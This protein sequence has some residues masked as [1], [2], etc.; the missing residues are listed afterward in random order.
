MATAGE[1]FRDLMH[2]LGFL[3]RVPLPGRYFVGY[4]GSLDRASG[5]FAVAGALIALPG[6]LLFGLCLHFDVSPNLA[7]LLALALQTGLTGGLHEDGLADCADGFGGGRTRD[8]ILDIMKDSRL[9]AY[10]GMALVFSFLLRMEALA[11]IG[12]ASGPLAAA[13]AVVAANAAS[14]AALV[15]HWSDLPP[16]K[17]AGVAAG[18]GQPTAA[19]S[20]VA[21]ASGLVLY[22]LLTGS[23][24]GPLPSVAGAVAVVLAMLAFRRLTRGKIQGHTGDTLGASEQVAEMAVFVAL[25]LVS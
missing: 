3:S 9:G 16:A 1:M 17:S 12:V 7:A 8:R 10:G 14:R 5:T 23:A 13:L 4:S 25:A 19:A 18:A 2:A 21:I 6:A 15:W 24:L 20:L 11:V 22:L